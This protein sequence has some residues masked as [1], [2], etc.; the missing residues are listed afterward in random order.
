MMKEFKVFTIQSIISDS[1][2]S[3]PEE[4]VDAISD[5]KELFDAVSD[6]KI[7][8]SSDPKVA[9]YTT[10]GKYPNKSLANR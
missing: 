1:A 3:N 10:N 4:L 5:S 6:P 2:H 8:P 9:T 7:D